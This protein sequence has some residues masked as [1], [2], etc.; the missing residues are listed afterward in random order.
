MEEIYKD[1]SIAIFKL[2]GSGIILIAVSLG[3]IITGEIILIIM[4][5]H[6][7]LPCII[8]RILG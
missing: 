3:F 4:G 8:W 7:C 1:K 5:L 2:L 6:F